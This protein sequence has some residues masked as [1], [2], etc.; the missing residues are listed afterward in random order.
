VQVKIDSVRC[1][2]NN[3]E[4][5]AF[6]DLC[7]FKGTYYLTFRSCPDG[8]MVFPTSRIRVLRSSDGLAWQQ[9]CEFGVPERD[10]RDPHFLVFG[11]TIFVYTGTW[12]CEDTLDINHHLGYC[13]WSKDGETWQGPRLLEGTYGH[14][15]WRATAWN[16]KAYL[17]GRRKREFARTTDHGDGTRVTE[18]ALMESDDGFVY[19]PVGLFQEEWGDETAFLFEPDGTL[20]AL[21]RDGKGKNAL[22]CRS[23]QPFAEWSRVE[24]E[25]QVGGPMLVKWAGRYLIGGRKSAPDTPPKTALWWIV[26]DRMEEIAELPSGGDTSYPGFIALNDSE[27]LLSYY[28]SHEGSGAKL[29]PSAIYLADLTIVT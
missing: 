6:T 29:A 5:N 14:Y 15:I 26:N 4:H 22:I 21:A 28:S 17:C 9:V 7:Q 23:R 10:V 11:D 24:L 20:V 25:R 13:S 1:V 18:S 12:L 27:G 19:K 2:F 8:H 3:G 16:G